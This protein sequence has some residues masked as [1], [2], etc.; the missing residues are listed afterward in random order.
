MT[1]EGVPIAICSLKRFDNSE[2]RIRLK[3]TKVNTLQR[4]IAIALL[5]VYALNGTAALPAMAAFLAYLDGGHHVVVT[6]TQSGAHLYLKHQQ[7]DVTLAAEEHRSSAGRLVTRFCRNNSSGTHEFDFQQ[8][9]PTISLDRELKK[10]QEH[11]PSPELNHRASLVL[12]MVSPACLSESHKSNRNR[13]AARHIVQPSLWPMMAT[14][15]L[16]L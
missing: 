3:L 15:Q 9:S 10:A 14:V 12:E 13:D 11:P 2:S 5:G 1:L 6:V 7:S 16:L 8:L 4:I